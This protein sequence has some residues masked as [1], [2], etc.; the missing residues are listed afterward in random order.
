MRRCSFGCKN[1]VNDEC[2]LTIV[3]PACLIE[4]VQPPPQHQFIMGV[5]VPSPYR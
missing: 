4:A 1:D 3:E 5:G 2:S